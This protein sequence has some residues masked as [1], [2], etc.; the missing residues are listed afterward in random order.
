MQ[1]SLQHLAISPSGFVFDPTSGST[2]TANPSARVLLEG[3]RD[4]L[5]LDELVQRLE[6]DF[7]QQGA[8]LRRDIL[9][10]VRI[11]RDETL[12]PHDFEL[13]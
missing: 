4:G 12:L 13:E 7:E 6:D 8:D 10:F 3:I 9:E 11:L 5:S 2:F 1:D